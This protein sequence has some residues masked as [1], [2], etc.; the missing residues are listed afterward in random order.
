VVGISEHWQSGQFQEGLRRM[1]DF[2]EAYKRPIGPRGLFHAQAK[3]CVLMNGDS[4][5]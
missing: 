2:L 1:P 3:A 5:S 4:D